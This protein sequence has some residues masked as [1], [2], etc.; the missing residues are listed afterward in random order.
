MA[1]KPSVFLQ[2]VRGVRLRLLLGLIQGYVRA[3][4]AIALSRGC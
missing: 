3:L 1:W 4:Q 2:E